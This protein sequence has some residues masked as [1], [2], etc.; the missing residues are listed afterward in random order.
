VLSWFWVAN[1]KP[2]FRTRPARV[3]VIEV[4]LGAGEGLDHD[5]GG[6][7]GGR[8]RWLWGCL[9]QELRPCVRVA[10]IR[11]PELIQQLETLLPP[12]PPQRDG[13]E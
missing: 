5:P 11:I 12:L 7:R 2:A 3:L 6:F 4:D 10:T 1:H 8:F 13:G 9:R